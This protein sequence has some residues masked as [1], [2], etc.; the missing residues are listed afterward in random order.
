MMKLAMFAAL[1]ALSWGFLTAP[2]QA[3]SCP[4]NPVK[5]SYAIWKAANSK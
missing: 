5:A 4:A 1:A 3:V 2:A